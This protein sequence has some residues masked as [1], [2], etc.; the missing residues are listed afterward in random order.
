[1]N[2]ADVIDELRKKSLNNGGALGKHAGI[3]DEAADL[4]EKQ[5]PK[6]IAYEGE[7]SHVKAFDGKNKIL[8]YECYPCPNCGRWVVAN[9]SRKYC[10]YCGQML[11][12]EVVKE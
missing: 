11:D 10:E 7:P 9:T 6:K 4:L 2:L 12:W 8:T 1:M 3:Y 5:I